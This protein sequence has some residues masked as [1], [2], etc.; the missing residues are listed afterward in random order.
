MLNRFRIRFL[1]FLLP[2]ILLFA[3]QAAL[4]HLASHAAGE[5]PNPKSSLVHEKLC[6]SC[7]AVEKLTNAA[8]DIGHQPKV[9]ENHFHHIAALPTQVRSHIAVRQACRDPPR[10][11]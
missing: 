9:V 4:A 8:V 10:N 6:G 2:A 1:F 7:L 5:T 3:Q 11:V